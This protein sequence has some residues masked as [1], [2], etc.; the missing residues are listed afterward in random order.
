MN[1]ILKRLVSLL[2]CFVLVAGYLPAGAFAAETEEA[3]TA[4]TTAVTEEPT[5]VASEETEAPSESK[6]E[7]TEQSEQA[8]ASAKEEKKSEKEAKKE[9]KQEKTVS[10]EETSGVLTASAEAAAIS[11]EATEA[12]EPEV[13][14]VTGIT[15]DQTELEVSVGELPMTLTATVLPEN[16]TDKT[17]TWESSEPGVASVEDGVL[18]F[19]YMGKAV[20]TATAADGYGAT[21]TVTIT[22]MKPGVEG[23]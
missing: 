19:G 22:V 10:A 2:L 7:S 6:E 14:A 8:D 16:A 18:T 17:V 1:T 9:A 11:V 20:I 12:T 13:I 21:Q 15:L 23:M 3:V 4:E 5:Q